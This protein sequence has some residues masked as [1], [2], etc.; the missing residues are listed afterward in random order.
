[1]RFKFLYT[2]VLLV[3]LSFKSY[4][5]VPPMSLGGPQGI[6]VTRSLNQF[7][8]SVPIYTDTPAAPLTGSGWP[9]RGYLAFIVKPDTC[10]AGNNCPPKDSSLWE[11]TGQRWK[12]VGMDYFTKL[13]FGGNVT[14]NGS[15]ARQHVV[16]SYGAFINGAYYRQPSSVAVTADPKAADSTSRI[17]VI[18]I[19]KTGVVI[20]KGE[21][22][23]IP[24][25]PALQADE[26]ELSTIFFRA[27][28]TVPRFIPSTA[29]GVT[30]IFR[31]AG[32]DSIYFSIDTSTLAIK[33]SI[34]ITTASNGLTRV[35]NDVKI[36]GS[37]TENT[38]INL[39]TRNLSI[40]T[41]SDTTR[42]FPSGNVSIGGSPLN[43]SFKLNVN[44]NSRV[45]GY[46]FSPSSSSGSG[47]L[48]GDTTYIGNSFFIRAHSDVI[49]PGIQKLKG[50]NQPVEF[51]QRG[52]STNPYIWSFSNTDNASRPMSVG[53]NNTASVIKISTGLGNANADG[54]FG[55]VLELS[56]THNITDT[57]SNKKIRGIYY[58]PSITSLNNTAHISYEN[59]TGS[60]IL[61]SVS[62]NTRIGYSTFDTTYKLDVN[63]HAKVFRTLTVGSTDRDTINDQ[64]AN[65]YSDKEII[66]KDG[67]FLS[68][69][70]SPRIK[71]GMDEISGLLRFWSGNAPIA[72]VNYLGAGTNSFDFKV[73]DQHQ[74]A[75]GTSGN[76]NTVEIIGSLLN[77]GANTTIH[78]QIAILPQIRDS[79]S[80]SKWRGI[81]YAPDIVYTASPL[82]HI[83]YENTSGSNLLNT[84]SGNTRIGYNTN[85]TTFKLDV[86]GDA[87]V[88]RLLV[89]TT[90]L[91]TSAAA[92]IVSTTKGFLQPRMTNTQRDAITSPATGLQLFSTTDSANYVYRGTDGGWQKITNEIS[93]SAT[94]DFPSTNNGNESD[95]TITVTGASDGDVVSLG[96]PNSVNLNHSCFTAWVS[97]TNTVTVR[98]NNYG[99]GALN[100]VSATFKVKV[101]K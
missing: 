19:T 73:S 40:I 100:P 91:D 13:I 49:A 3:V 64:Y 94:L 4:S 65:I 20:K 25:K 82:N 76:V 70:N 37:L 101:F 15:F 21:S 29:T 2:I 32:R 87:R 6:T 95:L 74:P 24:F 38:S 88:T 69:P 41:G 36:G 83:A 80:I 67:F 71:N 39:N 68:G 57:F 42:F 86:N 59:T 50:N 61:N 55:N 18:A 90:T 96:V 16:S 44:G 78:N 58:S 11:Y 5:Q 46:I 99:T 9:G 14:Q 77:G 10:I 17:D 56:P 48:I 75:A 45:T 62:G 28:D 27:F 92:N 66:A 79:F 89:N 81:Y 63:G 51:Y 52:V 72:Y 85:D 98:F 12:R 8:M 35:G 60:N 34:G 53:T 43:T 22:R 93:G 97:A 31:I 7:W 47:I 54:I 84:T 1:M 23:L 26:I 30:N 33:D